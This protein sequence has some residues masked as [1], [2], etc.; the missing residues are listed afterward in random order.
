VV[1]D[2]DTVAREAEQERLAQKAKEGV[3]EEWNA[4]G[5]SP[6]SLVN[7]SMVTS[8]GNQA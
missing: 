7:R 1:G 8:S 5:P 6:I 4:Q 3:D 2:T